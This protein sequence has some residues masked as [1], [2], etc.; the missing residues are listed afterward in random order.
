MVF[1]GPAVLILLA[2]LAPLWITL[3][4]YI[5]AAVLHV[6]LLILRGAAFRF[7]TTFKVVSYTA[8][9]QVW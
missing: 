2:I 3:T 7:R 4:L 9:A 8:A 5:E 1:G 6:S